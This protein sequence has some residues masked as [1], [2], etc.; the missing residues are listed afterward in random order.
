MFCPCECVCVVCLDPELLCAGWHSI[1][2]SVCTS[3]TL[4]RPIWVLQ[5]NLRGVL[6]K[7]PFLVA[8]FKGGSWFHLEMARESIDNLG[9]FET[10]SPGSPVENAG[11]VEHAQAGQISVSSHWI[12]LVCMD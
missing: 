9:T 5:N 1:Q 2:V 6:H 12:S 3:M 11:S 8:R 10:F 7:F 4:P